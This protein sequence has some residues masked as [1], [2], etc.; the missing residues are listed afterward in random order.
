MSLLEFEAREVMEEVGRE[1]EEAEVKL[2][3]EVVVVV[4][5]AL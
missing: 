2:V 5:L 1:M 4:V 3:V